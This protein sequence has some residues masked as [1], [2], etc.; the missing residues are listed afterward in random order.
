MIDW[1]LLPPPVGAGQLALFIAFLVASYTIVCVPCC[2]FMCMDD[3]FN[4]FAG[5]AI[6]VEI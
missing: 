4:G 6:V 3:D 2:A 5:L 1:C